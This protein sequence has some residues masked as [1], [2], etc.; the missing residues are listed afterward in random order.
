MRRRRARP[1]LGAQFLDG[2]NER[3]SGRRRQDAGLHVLQLLQDLGRNQAA[4]EAREAVVRVV[5]GASLTG[6]G[7]ALLF[8]ARGQGEFDHLRLAAADERELHFVAG[9]ARTHERAELIGVEQHLVVEAGED[10]TLFDLADGRAFRVDE[11]DLDADIGRHG[12]DG[13]LEPRSDV[14]AGVADTFGGD[15]LGG[16]LFLVFGLQRADEA[17]E[18]EHVEGNLAE[19]VHGGSFVR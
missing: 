2:R 11:A 9:L 7:A 18:Q 5:D 19:G 10:I 13:R 3:A 1:G 4:V 17:G 8:G 15:D 14:E 16:G 12:G 6:G